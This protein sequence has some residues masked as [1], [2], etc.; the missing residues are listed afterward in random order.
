MDEIWGCFKYVGIPIETIYKMPTKN[1]KYFIQLH[2]GLMEKE[3]F[4][5]RKKNMSTNTGI[6][7]FAKM[8]QDKINNIARQ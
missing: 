1:R 7:A 5:R 4:K 2:N 3:N 6:N 8:E